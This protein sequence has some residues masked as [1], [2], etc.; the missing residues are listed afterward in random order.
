MDMLPPDIRQE[1]V[2]SAAALDGHTVTTHRFRAAGPPEPL[3]DAMRTR[4]RDEGLRFVEARNGEWH[5]LSARDAGGTRTVQLRPTAHGVEGL[6][7]FWRRGAAPDDESAAWPLP[8]V[9]AWLPGDARIVR[10]V[11]HRDPKRDAATVVALVD[12]SPEA[13]ADL[14][15]RAAARAGFDADPAL[16][17]P[18]QGAAWYRGGGMAGAALAFRRR[19]EEVVATVS[20]HRDG[21]ALVLHWSLAR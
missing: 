7:S 6:S 14:L 13:A 4:W 5:V 20:S 15:A 12:A 3:I 16:G 18:A 8:P 21:T 19:G 2:M 1:L 11:T 9:I 17:M 10:R